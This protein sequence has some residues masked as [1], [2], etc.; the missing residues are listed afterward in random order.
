MIAGPGASTPLVALL[1]GSV[2]AAVAVQVLAGPVHGLLDRLV[3][4][5]AGRV[6][7]EALKT[8]L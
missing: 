4:A 6:S 8:V 5:G 2:A 3:F 7:V 1:L